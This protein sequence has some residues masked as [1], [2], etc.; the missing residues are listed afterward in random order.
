MGT[1]MAILIWLVILAAVGWFLVGGG[2]AALSGT[3]RRTDEAGP[4]RTLRYAVPDGQDPAAVMA[5]LA[6]AGYVSKL[7]EQVDTRVLVIAR[8]DGE[9]PDPEAVRAVI[10]T[11]GTTLQDPAL[12]S[13]D[14][15]FLDEGQR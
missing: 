3:K 13:H 7:V 11:A 6:P 4:A 12:T 2:L 10:L 15:R 8:D 5:V 14:V 1:A 9:R